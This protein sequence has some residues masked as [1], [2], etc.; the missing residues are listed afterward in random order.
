MPRLAV[1]VAAMGAVVAAFVGFASAGS[2]AVGDPELELVGT[3]AA[4][5]F[6]TAPPGDGERIFV[7][8][9]GGRIM[10]VK[11][12]VKL[13]TP[14][15]DISGP[16][17]SS[18]YERGLLSMAFAPDYASSG[19]FYVYYTA[20]AV[21]AQRELGD[22]IIAE[23]RRSANPDVAET[24]E[25]VVLRITHPAS[26]HNGGQLQFG[27]DGYLYIGTGDGG[28]AGDPDDNGQDLSVLLG[29]LLRINP[30]AAGGA[31]YTIPPDN[32]FLGLAGHRPEIWAYG[33]RNPWR[34]SF[35][36][37]T[38]DLTIGDVG[39]NRL[40]EVDFAPAAGGRGKGMNFGWDCWEGTQTL[41]N[42]PPY[43][44]PR[45][46]NHIPP[47]H[48]YGRTRGRSITGGYV[49]RDPSLPALAGRYVYGDALTDPLWSVAL[50]TPTAADGRLLGLNVTDLYSF[51][52]D[53][54]GRVY[55]ASGGGSVYRLKASGSPSAPTCTPTA[56]PPPPPPPPGP[57]A[58]PPP[59]A[60]AKPKICRVPKLT[61]LRGVTA[62][63]RIRRANCRVGRVRSRRSVRR[64][65]RVLSQAPRPGAR[66][67][68][69]TRVHFTVSRGRR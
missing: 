18:D 48:E 30:L 53:A 24:A 55:A 57:P 54:C 15:L 64:R 39:Q 22:L 8:E 6:V 25:R 62:R 47:V 66:R 2:S 10:V 44:N 46:T 43:C 42:D 35:D 69:G 13:V 31:P 58:P 65:G 59:P 60:K 3:F 68:R 26:N 63:A 11:A 1:A 4:P 51:G 49:V 5:T 7:V 56:Q 9:K 36:R 52:E 16:V 20:D 29:K 33:L 14:F 34:F 17:Q 19:R 23:Y 32:P 28:G 67:V 40:E 27:P 61:G 21:P 41:N 12:G 38:G 45:P 50:Q 37:A